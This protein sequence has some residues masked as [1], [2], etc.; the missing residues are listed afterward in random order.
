MI[1]IP[2]KRKRTVIKHHADKTTHE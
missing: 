2:R 1:I